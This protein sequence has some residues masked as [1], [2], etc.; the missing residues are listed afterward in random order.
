[1][2]IGKADYEALDRMIRQVALRS[3]PCLAEVFASYRERGLTPKRA[4]W[5]QLWRAL[6][7][8]RQAFFD[9]VYRYADDRHVD[10]ALRSVM[11][12]LGYSWAGT[13]E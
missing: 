8:D 7:A 2:K 6:P 12:N 10:T 9:R 1:M 5:D 3:S 13:R 11:L 4:R